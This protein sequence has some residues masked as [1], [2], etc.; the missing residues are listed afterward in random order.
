MKVFI[1]VS[2]D[3]IKLLTAKQT[4]ILYYESPKLFMQRGY[5]YHGTQLNRLASIQQF[6]LKPYDQLHTKKP[7]TYATQRF[8]ENTRGGDKGTV[9]RLKRDDR[10]SNDDFYLKRY[11]HWITFK[12]IK[13]SEIEVITNKG[14]LPLSKVPLK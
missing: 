3:D 9:L 6:G 10:W 7:A 4:S 2:A 12:T 1:S 13:P 8:A 14:W 11:R 5:V